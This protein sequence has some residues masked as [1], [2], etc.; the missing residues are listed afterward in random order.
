MGKNWGV[1]TARYK[2]VEYPTGERQLFDLTADRYELTNLAADPA[3]AGAISALRSRLV[4][5]R[6][7]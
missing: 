3:Y 5:L 4:A 2:Y 7:F 1:R 6:G